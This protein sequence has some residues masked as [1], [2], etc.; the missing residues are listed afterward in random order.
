[1]KGQRVEDAKRREGAA[2]QAREE[3]IAEADSS[4]SRPKVMT[5]KESATH[6]VESLGPEAR[7]KDKEFKKQQKEIDRVKGEWRKVV[8]GMEDVGIGSDEFKAQ[9]LGLEQVVKTNHRDFKRATKDGGYDAG[10]KVK[11][12]LDNVGV[13][14]R[15]G[16]ALRGNFGAPGT[17]SELATEMRA[18]LKELAAFKNS[19]A[20]RGEE[21]AVSVGRAQ[22]ALSRIKRRKNQLKGYG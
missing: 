17:R 15:M 2:N 22:Q 6:L 8:Q 9:M 20:K 16:Q 1:M 7:K 14:A 12:R 19:S 13:F 5:S 3:A 11:K 18:D 10:Q 4:D 21:G